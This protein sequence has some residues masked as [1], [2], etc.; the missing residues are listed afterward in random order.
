MDKAQIAKVGIATRGNMTKYK[1]SK[2]TDLA[3]GQIERIEAGTHN[4]T[5]DILNK[6][7]TGLGLKMNIK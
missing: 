7:L 2:L 1:L 6:Y 4:Y 3:I 5:I